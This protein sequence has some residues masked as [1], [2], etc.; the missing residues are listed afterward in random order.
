MINFKK[1]YSNLKQSKYMVGNVDSYLAILTVFLL[2]LSSLILYAFIDRLFN[3]IEVKT[4]LT[5]YILFLIIKFFAYKL[6]LK[7]I[8]FSESQFYTEAFLPLFLIPIEIPFILIINN[9][10]YF[11][12]DFFKNFIPFLTGVPNIILTLLIFTFFSL[13]VFK[14]NVFSHKF[15]QIST[16]K[17]YIFLIIEMVLTSSL[18]YGI[19]IYVLKLSVSTLYLIR[20]TIIYLIL[21]Y[22]FYY[23]INFTQDTLLKIKYPED[24]SK[25]IP[26]KLL[27]LSGSI[28]KEIFIK[29]RSD[30]FVFKY[31]QILKYY[32]IK[33]RFGSYLIVLPEVSHLNIDPL[34][35][36][37]QQGDTVKIIGILFA[38]SFFEHKDI[39]YIYPLH[40]EISKKAF[41]RKL[42]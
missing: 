3:P 20:E 15:K 38:K 29:E 7:K 19:G 9:F 22:R 12:T 10:I 41:S 23:Y 18:F 4:V 8:S 14:Y 27:K 13:I 31:E 6:I 32:E 28:V 42:L 30:F 26:G 17:F 36:N 34:S 1:F 40:L 5:I 2:F 25:I 21:F 33:S 37:L 11:N 24:R 39:K 16:I 35:L